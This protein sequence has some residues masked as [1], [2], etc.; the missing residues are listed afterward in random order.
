VLYDGR[1]GS[2]THNCATPAHVSVSGGSMHMLMRHE[3]SGKCGAGWYTAGMRAKFGSSVDQRITIRF[4]VVS[5]GVIAHRNIPMRWPTSGIWPAEGEENFCEGHT[6]SDCWTFLHYGT[7]NSQIYNNY[8]IDLTQWHTLRFVRL[9][10][11]VK[12]YVDDMSEPVWTYVGSAV[13]L[14]DTLKHVVLQQ[15][16]KV[17]GC[18]AGTQ[19]TEDIQIDSIA[20]DVPAS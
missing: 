11:V 2:G 7:T 16:C 18:P 6:L 3:T 15:E 14:P 8:E 20:I 1:Y 12:A 13:T 4:R 5:D 9:N 17:T 19:G 10:H